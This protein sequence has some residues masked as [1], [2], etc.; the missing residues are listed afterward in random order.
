M[1]RLREP[2][3]STKLYMVV[4]N[5]LKLYPKEKPKSSVNIYRKVFLNEKHFSK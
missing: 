2:D 3:S 4:Y 1:E 5:C